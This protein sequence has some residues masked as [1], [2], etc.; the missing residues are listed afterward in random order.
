MVGGCRSGVV[1]QERSAPR[2]GS[3]HASAPPSP[4]VQAAWIPLASPALVPRRSSKSSPGVSRCIR[5]SGEYVGQGVLS[6]RVGLL[7][8]PVSGVRR[9]RVAFR[10]DLRRVVDGDP[11]S[12]HAPGRTESYGVVLTRIPDLLL[13]PVF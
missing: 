10:L 1:E 4:V 8:R 5:G 6:D 12:L 13:G 3:S 9:L 7:F 11:A 2:R